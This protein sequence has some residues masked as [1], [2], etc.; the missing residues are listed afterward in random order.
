MTDSIT[1]PLAGR[2]TNLVVRGITLSNSP[3]WTFVARGAENL[4]IDDVHV[5]TPPCDHGKNVGY[6]A[7]PNTDGFNIGS[8]NG[9]LITD[10]SVR[11]RDDCVRGHFDL[12]RSSPPFARCTPDRLAGVRVVG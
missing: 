5:T 10:S 4:W 9:V 2:N 6:T 1:R 8:S 7:A 12:R 11:N 3:F